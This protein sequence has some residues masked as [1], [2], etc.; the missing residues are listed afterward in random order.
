[1]IHPE[2]IQPSFQRNVPGENY[3]DMIKTSFPGNQQG[4]S[5]ISKTLA[6]NNF[7]FHCHVEWAFAQSLIPVNLLSGALFE[8][9]RCLH[10]SSDTAKY[11]SSALSSLNG[12]LFGIFG[13]RA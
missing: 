8:M 10:L 9:G 11:G 3:C 5:F 12:R 4:Q 1:M 13:T 2:N 6:L 7:L